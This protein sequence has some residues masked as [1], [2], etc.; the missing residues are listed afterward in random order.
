MS[1]TIPRPT[2][3]YGHPDYGQPDYGHPDYGQPDYG[4][5]DYGHPDY[6][7]PDYG[8]PDYGQPHYG[9][10]DYDYYTGRRLTALARDTSASVKDATATEPAPVAAATRRHLRG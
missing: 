9:Q 4:Q 7:Q 1:R 2:P 5:P 6:G 8:Q 3:D 10:P